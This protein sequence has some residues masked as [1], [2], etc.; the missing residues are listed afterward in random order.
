MGESRIS[1]YDVE[2]INLCHWDCL[3]ALGI[4]GYYGEDVAE[5][6]V[7]NWNQRKIDRGRGTGVRFYWFAEVMLIDGAALSS[8]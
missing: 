3:H 4:F 5:V 1:G 2:G 6:K 8:R 7:P